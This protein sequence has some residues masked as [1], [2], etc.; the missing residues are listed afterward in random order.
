[1]G[2]LGKS[3]G[4]ILDIAKPVLTAVN[5]ML[6]AAAGA[7]GGLA[8]GKNPLESILGSVGDLIP[9]GA[10]GIFKNLLGAFGGG[11][12]MDGAGGNNLLG[13][14]LGMVTGKGGIT[15]LLGGLTKGAESSGGL[16][17]LGLKN[18]QEQ[19]AQKM[20]GLLGGLFG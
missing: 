8:Q 3:F 11:G 14:L 5:P 6:G 13:G 7:L 10:G 17:D 2:S 20:G 4:S 18:V 9:G 19:A 1:M 15:D 12:M 16:S